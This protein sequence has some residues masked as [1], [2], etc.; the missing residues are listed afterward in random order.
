M[1]PYMYTT[2]VWAQGDEAN[3]ETAIS[4]DSK[5]TSYIYFA[6]SHAVLFRHSIQKYHMQ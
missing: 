5:K 6:G 1:F 3:I 4:N 2:Y